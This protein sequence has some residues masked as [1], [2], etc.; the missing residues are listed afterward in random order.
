MSCSLRVSF[1]VT[2]FFQLGWVVGRL[3]VTIGSGT[4]AS[5]LRKNHSFHHTTG[6][7]ETERQK[8]GLVP[9]PMQT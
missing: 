5:F 3:P 7:L 1:L 4:S 6:G 9:V 8:Y 2:P